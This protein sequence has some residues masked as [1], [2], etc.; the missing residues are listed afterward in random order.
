MK[1]LTAIALVLFL[2]AS[3]ASAQVSRPNPTATPQPD[4]IAGGGG[5]GLP[6][7]SAAPTCGNT[8]AKFYGDPTGCIYSCADGNVSI[9]SGVTCAFPTPHAT[10]TP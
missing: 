3:T 7:P 9:V 10:A 4:S 1:T 6:K 5:L 2:G 8:D